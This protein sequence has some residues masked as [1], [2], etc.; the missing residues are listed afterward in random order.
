MNIGELDIHLRRGHHVEAAYGRRGRLS[1]NLRQLGAVGAVTRPGGAGSQAAV[2]KVGLPPKGGASTRQHLAYLQWR[3]GH[4]HTHA[5]LYGPGARDPQAFAQAATQDP[6]QFRLVVSTKVDHLGEQRTAFIEAL[7]HQMERDLGR[8]LEWVAANHYDTDNPHTHL[9][10]RGVAEGEP[11]YMARSYFEHGIRDRA[12][13]ILTRMLGQQHR[14]V[15]RYQLEQTYIQERL[16]MNGMLRG[17]GDPDVYR[18]HQQQRTQQSQAL[19][20]QLGSFRQE[21]GVDALRAELMQHQ[22]R[23]QALQMQQRQWHDAQ[24][25]EW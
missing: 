13:A 15:Q 23:M 18:V 25:R 7:V 5:S 10:V 20:G 2:V 11:L 24:R 3:K 19:A 6:H 8:Q 9:V 1:A 21:Y 22:H 17:A 16:A 14:E 12:S 4:N